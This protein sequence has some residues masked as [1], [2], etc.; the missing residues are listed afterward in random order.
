ML[1]P[2]EV[3]TNSVLLNPVGSLP[4]VEDN[5]GWYISVV[6]GSLTGQLYVNKLDVS[7]KAL[8]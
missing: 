7:K 3:G 1:C 4:F 5:N 2:P 6:C 8:G